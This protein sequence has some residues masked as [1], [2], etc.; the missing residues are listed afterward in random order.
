MGDLGSGGVLVGAGVPTEWEWTMAEREGSGT[1]GV[2]RLSDL[3]FSQTGLMLR[4]DVGETELG[5]IPS[6]YSTRPDGR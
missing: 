6:L 2:V 5:A 1:V 3:N 4:M